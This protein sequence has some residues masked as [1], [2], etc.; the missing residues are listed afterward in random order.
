MCGRYTNTGVDTRRLGERFGVP[1]SAIGRETVGRFNVCPTE[2]ILVVAEHEGERRAAAPRWGL[3]PPNRD[4]PLCLNARA[5]TAAEKGMFAALLA[6][7]GGRCLVVADGWYEWLKPEA[8]KGAKIPFHYVVDGGEPF[9]FAGLWARGGAC[10]LTTG[11][12]EVCRPVHDRMP[13][14]LSGPEAEALWLSP[15]VDVAAARELLAPLPSDRISAR[16]VNPAVNKAGVEG[17]E[18]LVA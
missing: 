9:A 3:T 5:E 16:P 10:I 4:K 1:P 12:N 11:A 7:S 17:P 18:L 13:C 15:E 8:P 14:I 2:S 6:R